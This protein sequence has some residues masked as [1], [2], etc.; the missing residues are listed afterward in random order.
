[1]K[2][3]IIAIGTELLIGQ[4]I[5]TNSGDIA[6]KFAPY[7]WEVNDVQVVDDNTREIVRAIDRA[8]ES[9]DIVITTG[10]LGPTKDD[11]TKATLCE[12]FGGEMQEDPSVLDNIKR[13]FEK[14][15][16]TLNELTARQAVVP[17]SCK[18]IQNT[19]GTA[20]IM[21]FEK[22]GK[23]L[24]SM[25][26]VPFE[27]REMLDTAV[28]PALLDKF[29]SDINIEHR[30]VL[31]TG[32]TESLLAMTISEWEDALPSWLHLAY[33]PK[34]GLVRLRIDGKHPDKEFLTHEIDRCHTELCKMLGDHVLCDR[35][36]PIESLIIEE[37]RKRGMSL[38]TAEAAREET[39]H[40][41]LQ[42]YPD[43]PMCS[44]EV[45]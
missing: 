7:G 36:I 4:V 22:D 42:P 25:P 28:I 41:R 13:V 9:S 24:V 17:T 2:I 34:P 16:L 12:Y 30:C 8:F 40:T 32:Y 29:K 3:S 31:V 38:S 10:G 20:P 18:V 5:D 37:L 23:V 39:S 14:R 21:W 19:V 45:W 1:M 26:G 33:L 35:D 44:T 15:G 27:T 43:A 11:I 6:R